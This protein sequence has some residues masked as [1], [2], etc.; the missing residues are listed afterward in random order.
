MRWRTW[1][2]SERLD[3]CG[4]SIPLASDG[5]LTLK[6]PNVSGLSVSFGCRADQPFRVFTLALKIAR[7][8][9]CNWR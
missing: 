4:G 9:A 7:D 1:T 5:T 2:H 6:P 8:L 3:S